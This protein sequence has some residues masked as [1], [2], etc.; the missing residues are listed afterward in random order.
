MDA[1]ITNGRSAP[2]MVGT[3]GPLGFPTNV[4]VF[5]TSSFTIHTTFPTGP[6]THFYGDDWS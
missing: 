6:I 3:T 4:V 5:I 2:H 1:S